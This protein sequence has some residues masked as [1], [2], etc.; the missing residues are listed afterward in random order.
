M[1][2]IKLTRTIDI[3]VCGD[4]GQYCSKKCPF[5]REN[6]C[7]YENSSSHWCGHFDFDLTKSEDDI[8]YHNRCSECNRSF[9]QLGL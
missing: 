4:K 1:K 8:G 9:R 5:Y 3:V 2:D 7:Y 6:T